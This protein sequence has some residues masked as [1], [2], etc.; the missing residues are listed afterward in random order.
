MQMT[1][2][3]TTQILENEQV[4]RKL[5]W[6]KQLQMVILFAKILKPKDPFKPNNF[7]GGSIS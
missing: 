4:G 3:I 7:I 1:K 6:E 5:L 2:D